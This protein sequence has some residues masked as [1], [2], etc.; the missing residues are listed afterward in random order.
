MTIALAT[1][2]T[3]SIPPVYSVEEIPL[4]CICESTTNPRRQFDEVKLAE[5]M[6]VKPN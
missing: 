3:S 5:L 2:A 4:A 1:P 6:P